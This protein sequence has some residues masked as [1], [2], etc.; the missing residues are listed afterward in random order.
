VE[1]EPLEQLTEAELAMVREACNLQVHFFRFR[2]ER[3][4]H[5]V[6]KLNLTVRAQR[7]ESALKNFLP[8]CVPGTDTRL[9]SVPVPKRDCPRFLAHH[10]A[11]SL[12]TRRRRFRVARAFPSR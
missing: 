1:R 3:A 5:A 2:A 12:S 8:K 9:Q 4:E 7:T 10:P 11:A 6:E